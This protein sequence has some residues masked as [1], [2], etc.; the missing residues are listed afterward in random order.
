MRDDQFGAAVA[1]PHCQGV[2]RLPKTADGSPTDDQSRRYEPSGT[3]TNSV[4]LLVSMVLH[5][6]GLIIF[7]LITF[8]GRGLP[9]EGNE[10]SIGTL[11]GEVLSQ[12]QD[13]A[14]DATA[15]AQDKS[16]PAD[17]LEELDIAPP[18]E[19]SDPTA[20]V[21]FAL[22]PTSMSGS[23]GGSFDIGMMGAAGGGGGGGWDGMIQRLRQ[24]GLDVVIVFDSTGS[25]G[26][27][28]DAVKNQI[29]RIGTTLVKLV[30]KARLSLV[31]Y[32][33][34]GDEY[35]VKDPILPL[36]G[37]IQLV[38][39]YLDRVRA[40]GGGDHPEA[41]RAGLGAAIA[42]N[43]FRSSGRKVI[44]LFGDAP[45]HEENF[46]ACLRLAS[47]FSRQNKGTVST[48]TCRGQTRLKEFIEIAQVG[49]GEAFLSTDE[50][51]IMTQ[52]MVL[53]FGSQYRGKVVEAF[54]LLE[55]EVLAA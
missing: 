32:R 38:Q 23:A 53:V 34:E 2:V 48:V 54:E 25:M 5:V 10:V 7:A 49:G 22:S 20:A 4:A 55:R 35:I 11:P 16:D 30:P 27:E 36:T 40:A 26:G 19:T 44:L 46:A 51:Q 29:S 45:P 42:Q 18:N 47:D 15:E 9:G 52:L 21:E 13:D 3:M 37:D 24:N 39:Q 31:T 8:G 50:K 41:V 14:L 1:C 43:D 28:I 17:A 33:D 6:S 12:N